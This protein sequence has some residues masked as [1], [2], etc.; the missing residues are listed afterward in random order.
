MSFRHDMT[1]KSVQAQAIVRQ[2]DKEQERRRE[3]SEERKKEEALLNKIKAVLKESESVMDV[4]KISI[5][6]NEPEPNVLKVINNVQH[7][8]IER[9][10]V[11]KHPKS[12]A[13]KIGRKA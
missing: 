2:R 6:V 1:D 9:V 8:I 13:Y 5:E 10:L 4:H 12:V 11:E 3:E 7:E